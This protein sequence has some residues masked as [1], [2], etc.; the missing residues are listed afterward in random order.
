MVTFIPV[1]P[2]SIADDRLGRRGRI[3]YPLL[4]SFMEANIKCAKIDMT[5]LQKNQQ[6]LRSVLSAYVKSHNLPITLFAAQGDLHM[7][8]LD[9]DNQNNKIPDW[10]EQMQ[11]TEGAAGHL[12]HVEAKPLNATE[13]TNRFAT[14]KNKAAK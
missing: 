8:R 4:K 5:G 3:S 10:E 11:T 9:L 13:V 12:Q 7:M 14:E 1:D 6:Y 2:S